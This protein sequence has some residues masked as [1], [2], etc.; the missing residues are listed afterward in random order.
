MTL[1]EVAVGMLLLGTLMASSLLAI[2]GHARQI[3]LA[4]DQLRATNELNRLLAEWSTASLPL[5]PAVEGPC[6]TASDLVWRATIRSDSAA[7]N[8]GAVVVRIEVLKQ[9]MLSDDPQEQMKQVLASVEVLAE[10][11]SR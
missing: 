9:D 11:K 10:G 4:Q 5:P 7:V 2:S 3:S 8:L 1:I 6:P